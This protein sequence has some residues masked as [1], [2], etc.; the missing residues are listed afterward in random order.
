[1]NAVATPLPNGA[2]TLLQR[3][4]LM[5]Y[6][7]LRSDQ[8]TADDISGIAG[9]LGFK[10]DPGSVNVKSVSDAMREG[11]ATTVADVLAKPE[12]MSTFA[13]FANNSSAVQHIERVCRICELTFDVKVTAEAERTGFVAASCPG[14][15]ANYRVTPDGLEFATG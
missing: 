7:G 13:A 15:F 11:G 12:I 6:A 3:F 10:I 5:K 9:I 8:I 14:C 1:M 2:I 4:G